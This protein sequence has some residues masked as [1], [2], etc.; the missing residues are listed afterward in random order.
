MSTSWRVS[1]PNASSADGS[2]QMCWFQFVWGFVLGCLSV[3]FALG[4]VEGTFRERERQTERERDRET[5][6]ET[7]ERERERDGHTEADRQKLLYIKCG[8]GKCFRRLD[9]ERGR[10]T[11][12][13][14]ETEA[15]RNTEADRQKI[16]YIKCGNG[17]CFRRVVRP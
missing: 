3:I 17:K 7:E 13:D 15:D 5:P 8:N 11:Q 4:Y 12:T 1:S 6:R 10:D 2:I 9:R 14:R 16:L